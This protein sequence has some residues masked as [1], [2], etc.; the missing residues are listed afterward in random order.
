VNCKI[1]HTA[2]LSMF[3]T[4]F[5]NFDVLTS[6]ACNIRPM[7]PELNPSIQSRLQGL[8]SRAAAQGANLQWALTRHWNRRRYGAG[9]LGFTTR[10]RM[11]PKIVGNLGTRRKNIRRPCFRPVR[12]K[13][14]RFERAPN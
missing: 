4:E 8:A 7:E 2:Q 1:A 14:W 3:L 12:F 9:K 13:E 10:G 5:I 11:S 6:T